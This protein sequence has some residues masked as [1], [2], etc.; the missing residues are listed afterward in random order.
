MTS[1]Q[2]AKVGRIT[3]AK[4]F[5]KLDLEKIDSKKGDY[6]SYYKNSQLQSDTK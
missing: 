2:N 5:Y 3:V 1:T 6:K 4:S